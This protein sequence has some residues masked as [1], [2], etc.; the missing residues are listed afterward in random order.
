[1]GGSGV[2]VGKP[3]LLTIGVGRL[4]AALNQLPP[5]SDSQSCTLIGYPTD[6]SLVFTF[7]DRAPLVVS[8]DRNCQLVVTAEHMRSYRGGGPLA[9]FDNLY[10][11]QAG[12]QTS[13]A[14]TQET[15][16]QDP[17]RG[18]HS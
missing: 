3:R 2:V 6:L 17:P 13:Q 10:S 8:L 4:V 7:A 9:L 14:P 15:H 5:V 11:A 1:L 12:D 16:P 18:S